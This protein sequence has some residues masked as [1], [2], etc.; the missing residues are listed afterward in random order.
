MSAQQTEGRT[1]V[2]QHHSVRPLRAEHDKKAVT[3]VASRFKICII[4]LYGYTENYALRA[5]VCGVRKKH[6]FEVFDGFISF[7]YFLCQYKGYP[8]KYPMESS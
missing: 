2:G 8:F 6:I 7:M 3:S 5:H 4:H 1:V